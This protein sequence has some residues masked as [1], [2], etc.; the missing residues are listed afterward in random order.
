MYKPGDKV[1]YLG[2][3]DPSGFWE[4]ADVIID[5]GYLTV[6]EEYEV[7]EKPR[8]A[9]TR[10]HTVYVLNNGGSVFGLSIHSVQRASRKSRFARNLPEWF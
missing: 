3:P 8:W 1:I 10:P 7:Q 5:G 6:D 2:K 4:D 9:T